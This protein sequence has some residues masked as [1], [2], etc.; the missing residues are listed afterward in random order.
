MNTETEI[1]KWF[2]RENSEYLST[3]ELK[4][5]ENSLDCSLALLIYCEKHKIP[6]P[7]AEDHIESVVRE[8]G[9]FWDQCLKMA[10]TE[11]AGID[12]TTPTN[13]A[14]IDAKALVCGFDM[15]ID[16]FTEGM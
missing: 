12:F 13:N 9:E 4:A 15:L 2:L 16:A 6:C 1:K 5:Y 14:L 3:Q 8:P 10:M 11:F 7:K